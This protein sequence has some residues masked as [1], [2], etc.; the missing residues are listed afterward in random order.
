MHIKMFYKSQVEVS[1]VINKIIDA[2]WKNEIKETIMINELNKVLQNNYSKIMKDKKYT[3][4]I[5][6][7]CGKR[8][9]E[10]VSKVIN[11][12]NK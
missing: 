9:L 6:Q 1:E 11:L 12:S 5:E 10:I 7:R 2:Y 8:R 3:K 4:I